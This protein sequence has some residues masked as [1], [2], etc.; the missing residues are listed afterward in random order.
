M[1]PNTSFAVALV[2]L[3]LG[4]G[5]FTWAHVTVLAASLIAA[6]GVGATLRA[7]AANAR[8]Q[9]LTTLYGDALGAVAEYL[10]GPYRILRKDGEASTRFAITNKLSDVKTN[11]DHHQALL[12]LHA[13]PLVADAYDHYVNIAKTEA[14]TQMHDAWEAPA[15]I[16]DADVNLDTPLPRDAS[17]QARALAV[18]MMQAHLRHRWYHADARQ[19]YATAER[20]V[21]AAIEA[22]RLD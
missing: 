11:I 10:E 7:N 22:R 6:T 18:E 2:P 13:E 4:L 19:R 17:E 14:G 20:A 21:R 16:Q 15:V 9:N 1:E 12:R 3:L 5:D 8:R